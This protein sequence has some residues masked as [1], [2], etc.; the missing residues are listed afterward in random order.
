[1]PFGVAAEGRRSERTWGHLVT[2]AYFTTLGVQPALGRFFDA[3]HERP[4]EAPAVVVS[5]RFWQNRL[6]ADPLIVGRSLRVNGTTCA[7]LGVGPREF[8][9]ASPMYFPADLWLPVTA[10]PRLTP[11]LAGHPLDRRDV[12]IFRVAGRLRPGV[13]PARAEAELDTAARQLE[14][15]YGEEDSRLRGRRLTLVPGGKLAPIRSQDVPM[16]TVLPLVL[17]SLILLIAC[18]NVANM[19]LARAVARRREIAVRLALGASRWRLVR[20]LLTESLLLAAA[21]AVLGW[22]LTV[23]LMRA[24]SGLRVPFPMPVQYDF[25]P[26]G[27]VLLF[28]LVL[29]VVTAL[30]F[31]LAPAL[32]ATR[33]DLTPALKEGGH[34]RLRRYRGLS[35]R[36]LLVLSQL[37]GSLTLL[38]ITGFLVLGFQRTTGIE[39]GFNPRNLWIVSLD[40]V[41]DG[42][43]GPQAAAFFRKLLDRVKTLPAVESATLTDTVPMSGGGFGTVNLFTPEAGGQRTL[44]TAVKYVV[45]KEY[46]Q[47]IGIP[48]LSGRAFRAEDEVDRAPAVIVSEDLVREFWPG[49]SPVGRRLELGRSEPGPGGNKL[50]PL[51]AIDLR[52]PRTVPQAF[53]V[54]GVVKGV[55]QGFGISK[56]QPAIYFPLQS[57]DYARPSL[58]GVTLMLRAAPG[59]DAIGVIRREIATLDERLSPF[60]AHGMPEQLDNLMFLLQTVVWMYGGMGLFGLVLAA[61]GLAGVTAHS[62]T[63]RTREIGIRIALGAS[64]ASVLGL[65]MREGA[66]MVLLG[67]AL[68]LALGWASTRVLSAFLNA[69]ARSTSTSTSDPLLLVGAPLLLAALAL[70]ACYLPALRST[71]IDP[72]VTLRAE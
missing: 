37:A 12:R 59:V 3:A 60:N 46:F 70:A 64:R 16:V 27:R 65:V 33:A 71:K 14:Q 54:V 36:N 15:A 8:L 22:T 9:G 13:T 56:P 23:W 42:Y 21:A 30:A 55:K 34:V 32:Q 72:A 53:E 62:V 41:R 61:V 11:E 68:G 52:P 26:D 39:V 44:H 45:G 63:Q 2:P 57:S 6:G 66:A 28:T 24:L 20:Q 10:D 35:L 51:G 58:Q 40:P 18:A 25:S 48:L 29:V 7:I 50:D 67:S 19:T 43:T 31:G 38:L 5:Y 49:E 47:T 69:M 1:V 4:R 17:V